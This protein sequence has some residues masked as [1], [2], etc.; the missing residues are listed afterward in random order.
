[1]L[2]K[3]THTQ[4][5]YSSSVINISALLMDDGIIMQLQL[6]PP[7]L[8]CPFVGQNHYRGKSMRAIQDGELENL[9]TSVLMAEHQTFSS[10][11]WRLVKFI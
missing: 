8:A 2:T 6:P 4:R 10:Q 5:K 9:Y 7:V 11:F 1:M 3:Y